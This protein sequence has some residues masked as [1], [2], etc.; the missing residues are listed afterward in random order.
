MRLT[1]SSIRKPLALLILVTLTAPTLA[2]SS[3]IPYELQPKSVLEIGCQGPCDCAVID[4]AAKGTF[5][6][7]SRGFDG[8]YE[9]YDVTDVDWDAPDATSSRHF[10]GFGHYRVGGEVAVMQEMVL[11]LLPDDGTPQRFSSGL[12]SGGGEFPKIDIKMAVHD[13]F[14]FDSVFSIHA[15]PVSA[16]VVPAPDVTLK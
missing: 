8:L 15:A 4:Y 7:V 5:V 14:C 13:F 11:D 2:A 12:V 9:N 10:T 3:T 6:L 16:S 1:C